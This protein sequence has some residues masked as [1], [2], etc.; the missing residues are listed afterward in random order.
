MNAQLEIPFV[1]KVPDSIYFDDDVNDTLTLSALNLPVWM[2]FDPINREFR[3]VPNS[4][5][6]SGNITIRVTDL[7][8]SSSA[9]SFSV[10]VQD[11]LDPKK[12]GSSF[13]QNE[14]DFKKD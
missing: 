7:A 2:T 1:Y 11:T 4:K 3:G 14:S 10:I 13:K 8:K 12:D 9:V 6:D 5:L